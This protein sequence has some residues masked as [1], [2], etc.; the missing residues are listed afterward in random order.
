[1]SQFSETKQRKS[2]QREITKSA[3]NSVHEAD[4]RAPT[5]SKTKG[6]AKLA[7]VNSGQSFKVQQRE[8][9]DPRG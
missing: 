2:S 4:Q 1:M 3:V 9:S 8:S 6:E 5:G 7:S